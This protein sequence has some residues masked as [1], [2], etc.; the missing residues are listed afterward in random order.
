MDCIYL[1]FRR[2]SSSSSSSSSST[3]FPPKL[4]F[5]RLHRRRFRARQSCL[6]MGSTTVFPCEPPP[7]RRRWWI[8][9]WR[10]WWGGGGGGGCL[11]TWVRIVVALSCYVCLFVCCVFIGPRY[12]QYKLM[13]RQ[14]KWRHLVANFATIASGASWWLNL[15]L[16]Q[17]ITFVTSK[18]VTRN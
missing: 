16:P 2:N 13:M 11:E 9:W 14:C 6:R 8:R 7:L 17:V 4:I 18:L 5:F 12:T 1:R 15:W 3:P 10:W